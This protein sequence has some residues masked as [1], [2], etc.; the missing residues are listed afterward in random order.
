MTKRL[1]ESVEQDIEEL[2]PHLMTRGEEAKIA[3]EAQLNE[4]GKIES[5]GMLKVL[6]DQK[7]RVETEYGKQIPSQMML[8]FDESEK[9]QYESNRRYW[10]RW[11]ET[12]DKDIEH[13]PA[14]ILDFYKTSS[15]RIEPLGIVYLWPVTG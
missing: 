12:V 10:K 11:L 9:K 1:H 3:A 5:E 7:K 6:Q 13:E 8:D 2:L 4:R 14:R 15:H